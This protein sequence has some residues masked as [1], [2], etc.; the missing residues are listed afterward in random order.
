[1][2]VN[3]LLTL[4]Q[5]HVLN[6]NWGNIK[7]KLVKI[8]VNHAALVHMRMYENYQCVKNVLLEEKHQTIK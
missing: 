4:E 7:A 5:Q 1:M 3:M 6:V 2:L 8:N